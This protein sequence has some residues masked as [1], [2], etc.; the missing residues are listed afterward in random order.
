M[1]AGEKNLFLNKIPHFGI[2][3]AAGR[4]ESDACPELRTAVFLSADLIKIYGTWVSFRN[5]KFK[6]VR[7]VTAGL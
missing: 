1:K 4:A 7:H 6:G 3:V 2:V 5:F